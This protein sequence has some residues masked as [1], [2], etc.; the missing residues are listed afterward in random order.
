MNSMLATY[1]DNHFFPSLSCFLGQTTFDHLIFLHYKRNLRL[2][3]FLR[4]II[5]AFSLIYDE[6]IAKI[7][8]KLSRGH[9]FSCEPPL[10][11]AIC[12][13]TCAS[14]R[15]VIYY[16]NV[17]FDSKIIIL[18]NC[19]FLYKNKFFIDRSTSLIFIN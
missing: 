17:V 2:K 10:E 1:I 14:C 6:N 11:N 7:N 8:T 16:K 12:L 13:F 18:K 15:V 19:F 5:I 9:H 4:K 3:T